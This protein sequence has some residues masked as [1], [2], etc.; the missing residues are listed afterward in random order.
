MKSTNTGSPIPF[1]MR[2]AFILG[3]SLFI[4]GLMKRTSHRDTPRD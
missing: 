1:V 4:A 3:V 2:A